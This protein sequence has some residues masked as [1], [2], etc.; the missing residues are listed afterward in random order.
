M[1]M[2]YVSG[3]ELFDYI[4]KH[5]RLK[6]P[7]ARRFFQQIISGVDYCHR[8]MVVHRDLKPENLLL[9]EKNNVKIADFGLSNIMTDGDFLRTS[10]GSPNYAAPEV[11]S[12][13]L[14]AG[15]EVDVWSCGVILYALLCG[16]LPF[17]DEHVPSLFRK[18]KSGVFPIPD[19]LEASLVSLLTQMLQVD[20][21]K[22][23]TIKDVIN[24]EWFQKDL[25]IYLFPPINE[26]E[27]SIIDIEAVREV[28]E[29]YNVPEEE[30][31]AALLGD[32]PHHHLS[33]A[34]NLIVDNKRIADETA[35]LSIEEFYQVTPN[36]LQQHDSHRHPERIAPSI[37]SKVTAN[38][39]STDASQ[40]KPMAKR[41]KWHLGIRSQSRPEDIMH[42]VFKAM[43]NLDMEWK[44]L[45][46]YHVIVRRRPDSS[47]PE[48]PRMSLQLY[49]VDARSYLLDFKSLVDEEAPGAGSACSSRHASLS[50][51]TKPA[52][53]RGGGRN[54]S[55][56]HS[57]SMDVSSPIQA[58]ADVTPPPSP[59]GAK[60]SQMARIN[61]EE[62]RGDII[63]EESRLKG[64]KC[65]KCHEEPAAHFSGAEPRCKPC[66]IHLA[67]SK[68]R[69]CLS[70]NRI[71]KGDEPKD[72]IVLYDG[73]AS[74]AF[75][76]HQIQ[77]ALNQTNFKRL[78]V[79]P[80][81][82]VLVSVCD[83]SEISLIL[84]RVSEIKNLLPDTVPWHIFHEAVGLLPNLEIDKNS[85]DMKCYGAEQ[86]PRL[87]E[88]L[89]SIKNSSYRTELHRIIR[90][91]AIF[92]ISKTLGIN[93]IMLPDN[94]DDLARLS[95]S[96]FALGRGAVT[97]SFS[98]VVD[99]RQAPSGITL[100][101]PLRDLAASEIAIANRIGEYKSSE[102]H[103]G[104]TL[105][106]NSPPS[107]SSIQDLTSSLVSTLSSEGFTS[108]VTTVLGTMSKIH[109]TSSK[110]TCKLCLLA[111]GKEN[112]NSTTPNQFCLTCTALINDVSNLESL[113]PLFR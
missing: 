89:S 61:I 14:Y 92:R 103:F 113:E 80:T 78:V 48:P 108:T 33:I 88:L 8:H 56:S 12:G 28:T 41:A 107:S 39:E 98:S 19:Y 77:D 46:P 73:T 86:I 74:A 51:Q 11:I 49:Q 20:P 15:P 75:L 52:L 5:G 84:S 6:T 97:S 25:P 82:A 1:I 64:V 18:I 66:F 44:V 31:T 47:V 13:K 109:A 2:E 53:M 54:S 95:L 76:L 24:H 29:R 45:N 4:V 55:L 112:M 102:L 60:L 100:I 36:K 10:C 105:E 71:F 21:M 65:G 63:S 96:L 26:S 94:G 37:S 59:N 32:D 72:A 70:K 16:T 106:D 57:L 43:K 17:D 83:E 104:K 42:E 101:R 38:L 110:V 85:E 40:Q 87:I 111:I 9:D 81:I 79:E 58:A 50:L 67:K 7:E 23:A 99:R 30:V 90:E 22:R 34:Y 69:T 27:A 91:R 93:K 35:K 68:F 62:K 3:G